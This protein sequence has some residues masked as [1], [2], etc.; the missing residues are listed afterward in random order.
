MIN[1]RLLILFVIISLGNS[2]FNAGGKQL[3]N[4]LKYL[5]DLRIN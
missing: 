3:S 2:A 4:T 5:L 1:K